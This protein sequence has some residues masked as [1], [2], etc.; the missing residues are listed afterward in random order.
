MI[1]PENIQK[2]LDTADAT[3]EKTLKDYNLPGL[4]VGKAK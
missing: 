2:V 1:L 3:V 4:G